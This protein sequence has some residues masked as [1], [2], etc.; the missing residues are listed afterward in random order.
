MLEPDFYIDAIK[1]QNYQRKIPI[2]PLYTDFSKI[3][4][5]K[6]TL[7]KMLKKWEFS[8]ETCNAKIRMLVEKIRINKGKFHEDIKYSECRTVLR[9][10]AASTK[11]NL[12]EFVQEKYL[13][14]IFEGANK[15]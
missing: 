6:L 3:S 13:I 8:M 9:V 1:T 11:Q 5:S 12:I 4:M 14:Q 2:L 10:R 15:L 7:I